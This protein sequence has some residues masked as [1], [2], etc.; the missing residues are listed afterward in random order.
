MIGNG[1]VWHGIPA[2]PV[3]IG[4]LAVAALAAALFLATR[5]GFFLA[6]TAIVDTPARLLGA[7]SLSRGNFWRILGLGLGLIVPIVIAAVA[8]VWAVCGAAFGDAI[9][10]LFS[11]SHDNTALFQMIR[12]HAGGIAVVCAVALLVLNAVFAGASEIAYARVAH[13]KTAASS[14][15][16]VGMAEP[17]YAAAASVPV[18]R[19]GVERFEPKF[20][21][22]EAPVKT[23]EVP[24]VPPEEPA[25]MSSAAD[26][27][28][29]VE[30]DAAQADEAREES[31]SETRTLNE[32]VSAEAAIATPDAEPVSEAAPE[33]SDA[34]IDA[35][36]ALSE[37]EPLAAH[38]DELPALDPLNHAAPAAPDPSGAPPVTP[39]PSFVKAQPSPKSEPSEAA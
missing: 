31:S 8:A 21:G 20:F 1:G 6:T 11:A 4:I 30:K 17:A 10:A 24:T 32:A 25:I 5:F 23:A 22:S 36:A 19:A 12:D 28:A 39:L 26:T 34:S 9:S 14:H 37:E 2:A 16:R 18:S 27:Q 13:H 15:E 29:T 38:K 7:W 35:A 33:T 3:M